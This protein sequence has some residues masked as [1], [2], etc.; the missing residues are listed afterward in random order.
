MCYCSYVST[1]LQRE[2]RFFQFKLWT[3]FSCSHQLDTDTVFACP[4]KA[5]IF[6]FPQYLIWWFFRRQNAWEPG[7]WNLWGGVDPQHPT[8]SIWSRSE[9]S[10]KKMKCCHYHCPEVY[11][12]QSSEWLMMYSHCSLPRW[13]VW[14]RLRK[15]GR[16]LDLRWLLAKTS[17]PSQ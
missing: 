14:S 8:C 12:S 11:L 16:G 4:L 7:K 5:I 9:P 10:L 15:R 1:L 2:T 3:C 13:R 6:V 17:P